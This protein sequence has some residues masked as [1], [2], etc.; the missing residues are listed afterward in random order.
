MT[1]TKELIQEHLGLA[2]R[3]QQLVLGKKK[4]EDGSTLGGS[5]V[6]QGSVLILLRVEHEEEM[7]VEKK[8]HQGTLKP[9]ARKKVLKEI[10]DARDDELYDEQFNGKINWGPTGEELEDM[11]GWIVGPPGSP[12][13]GGVFCLKIKVPPEYPFKPPQIHFDTKIYHP[14]IQS[15]G[16]MSLDIL[17]DQWSPALGISKVLRSIYSLVEDPNPEDPL[18][19]DIAQQ[20]LKD[21]EKFNE[22]AHQWTEWHATAVHHPWTHAT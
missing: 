15:N 14:N 5:G 22:I 19:P 10:E 4:L 6:V 11:T 9:F 3:L 8:T 16:S 17:R 21:R 2:P 1:A 12:Y 20:Y 18:R 13:E 7:E